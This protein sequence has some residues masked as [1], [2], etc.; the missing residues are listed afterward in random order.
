M[1]LTITYNKLW[2]LLSTY[3]L[4]SNLFN[5]LDTAD[6]G[7]TE[8]NFLA[9]LQISFPARN[10]VRGSAAAAGGKEKK[11]CRHATEE[12]EG[13]PPRTAASRAQSAVL[14]DSVNMV[15]IYRRCVEKIRNISILVNSV[16]MNPDKIDACMRM[17]RYVNYI[18]RNIHNILSV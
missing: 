10:I 2:V 8:D 15:L 12:E 1:S 7:H 9:C 4:K 17:T 3:K 5:E 13:P 14:A 6:T 11:R 16:W 18:L